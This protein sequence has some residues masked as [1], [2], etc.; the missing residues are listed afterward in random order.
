[1]NG[2]HNWWWM[3]ISCGELDDL[4]WPEVEAHCSCEIS[5]F[6]VT[7]FPFRLMIEVICLSGDLLQKVTSDCVWFGGFVVFLCK[8]IICLAAKYT[9]THTRTLLYLS[10]IPKR[11]LISIQSFKSS[12]CLCERHRHTHLHVHRRNALIHRND[13][14]CELT[15]TARVPCFSAPV[16][17]IPAEAATELNLSLRGRER[18]RWVGEGVAIKKIEYIWR[19]KEQEHTTYSSVCQLQRVYLQTPGREHDSKGNWMSYLLI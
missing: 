6:E 11:N 15:H 2:D 16:C 19:A 3:W 10:Q 13:T 1:M 17:G 14:W 8:S 18:V 5:K 9:L 4:H 7:V 12:I